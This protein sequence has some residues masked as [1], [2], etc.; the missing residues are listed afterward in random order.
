[1]KKLLLLRHAEALGYAES[2]KDIDRVLCHHGNQQARDISSF[3][4]DH[5]VIINKAIVS[6]ATRTQQTSAFIKNISEI[7]NSRLLYEA[8]LSDILNI[9]CNQSA[10]TSTLL[11]IGHNPTLS[12]LASSLSQDHINIPTAG[13]V[14]FPLEILDWSELMNDEVIWNCQKIFLS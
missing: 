1:L 2:L 4:H 5:N 14:E 7:E 8:T 3:L 9:I 13:L 11:I 6:T 12:F 10:D